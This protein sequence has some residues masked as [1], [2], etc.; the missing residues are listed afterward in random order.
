M[1]QHARTASLVIG[2]A[3]LSVALGTA[4]AWAVP[5][6]RETITFS[7]TFDD[8][9]LSDACG[10]DVTTT[11]NGRI[12]FLVFPTDRSGSRTSPRSTWISWRVLATTG[13]G[14]RTLGWI[15]SG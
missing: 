12:T 7:D 11:L 8:E 2:L 10:V 3:L 6:E 5:P 13:C 14:S 1:K 9:F 15:S 4:A